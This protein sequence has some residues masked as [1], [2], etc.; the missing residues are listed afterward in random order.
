LAAEVEKGVYEADL[1]S[2]PKFGLRAR[3]LFKGLRA[4]GFEH[5]Q[6][7]G[8][9]A[10]LVV[11]TQR[12]LVGLKNLESNLAIASCPCPVFSMMHQ[13]RANSLTPVFWHHV[14]QKNMGMAIAFYLINCIP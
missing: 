4:E 1:V 5:P 13:R 3:G 8:L 7:L 9:V 11:K 14:K 10:Q 2:N 12:R 6:R